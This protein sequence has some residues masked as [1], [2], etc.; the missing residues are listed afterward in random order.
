[1]KNV[2]L[3]SCKTVLGSKRKANCEWFDENAAEVKVLAESRRTA[4]LEWQRNPRKRSCKN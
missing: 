2:I 4:F 1:M 3:D